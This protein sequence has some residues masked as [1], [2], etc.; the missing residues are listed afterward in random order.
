MN[1]SSVRLLPSCL[2]LCAPLPML[3]QSSSLPGAD[4]ETYR[5]DTASLQVTFDYFLAT[6]K[7]S[8][9]DAPALLSNTATGNNDADLYGFSLSYGVRA[10]LFV[11]VSYATG[12]SGFQYTTTSST[13]PG[14]ELRNYPESDQKWYEVRVRWTPDSMLARATQMYFA[15]G[16]TLIESDD[17]T[18]TVAVQN[19]TVVIPRFASIYGK[20]DNLFATL[21]VG[22]GGVKPLESM[23]VGY[24]LEG[25]LLAGKFDALN[26]F[27]NPD[28]SSAGP[29]DTTKEDIWGLIGRAGV[30]ANIPMGSGGTTL[31][32]EGGARF[33]YWDF[34][35]SDQTVWGPYA[36]AGISRRF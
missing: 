18:Y 27:F 5:G 33:Y 16:I 29:R 30:F 32:I 2:V 26:D 13:N 19:G 21:G 3:A 12:N 36:K 1:P 23:S 28:G 6:D 15:G 20:S 10:G 7:A 22:I 34:G 11:D 35:G 9:P 25:S 14:F 8:A 24:K 4:V 17:S 31:L